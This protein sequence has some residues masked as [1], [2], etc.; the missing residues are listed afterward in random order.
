MAEG[1]RVWESELSFQNHLKGL[2]VCTPTERHITC[3]HAIY[4]AAQSPNIRGRPSYILFQHFR[5][6]VVCCANECA[7]SFIKVAPGLAEFISIK[8]ILALFSLLLTL[9]LEYVVGV[10]EV[11]LSAS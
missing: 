1:C 4:Y 8:S 5:R 3:Q 2:I 7:A 10:S 9:F 11:N 6:H